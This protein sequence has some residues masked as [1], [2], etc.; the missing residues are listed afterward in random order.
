MLHIWLAILRG[1][2]IVGLSSCCEC[3]DTCDEVEELSKKEELSKI[4]DLRRDVV[5]SF[6]GPD[7][8]AV[9]PFRSA[10][11]GQVWILN[12]KG[13][14]Q[15]PAEVVLGRFSED[16]FKVAETKLADFESAFESTFEWRR[17]FGA[18]ADFKL[19]IVKTAVK[20]AFKD[21]RVESLKMSIK[22]SNSVEEQL[23]NPKLVM[24]A[25]TDIASGDIAGNVMVIGV[26]RSHL[27]L[28]Y[29]A[30]DKKDRDLNLDLTAAI[31]KEAETANV[32][33]VS[34]ASTSNTARIV[35]ETSGSTGTVFM[36]TIRN[37]AEQHQD[38]DE[39]N[40][41]VN[42][43]CPG[44]SGV[45]EKRLLGYDQSTGE[46]VVAFELV[47]TASKEWLLQVENLSGKEIFSLR[48][49]ILI[50]NAYGQ[51]VDSLTGLILDLP[52]GEIQLKGRQIVFGQVQL[53]EAR[54]EVTLTDINLR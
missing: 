49:G 23:V 32:G 53:D 26:V 8:V 52:A 14:L 16:R 30:L 11:L 17:S 4:E 45:L 22:L 25:Y 31:N 54:F 37:I 50:K 13:Q 35:Q 39:I 12:C 9:L 47:E 20:A 2:I 33:Y 18:D 3:N 29:S 40:E 34:D 10:E 19:K 27:R 43:L 28:E 42:V 15:S 38:S 5:A 44:G 7:A 36:A 21:S 24:D 6:A 51:P 48:Y 46:T 1:L 41:Q